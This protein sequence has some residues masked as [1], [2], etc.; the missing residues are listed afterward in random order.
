MEKLLDLLGVAPGARDFACATAEHQL[1][2]GTPLPQPSAVFP[3]Y[4]EP[5][6]AE[7]PQAGAPGR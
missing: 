3:R 7:A 1:Q 4:V 5:E 2:S 6:A